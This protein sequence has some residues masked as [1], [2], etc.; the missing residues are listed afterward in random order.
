[1]AR[2]SSHLRVHRRGEP[3]PICEDETIS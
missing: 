1:M 3:C 2:V